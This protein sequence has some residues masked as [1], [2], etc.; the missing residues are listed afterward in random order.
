MGTRY[1]NVSKNWE[2]ITFYHL[3]I[4]DFTAV[5]YCSI[6]HRRVFVMRVLRLVMLY[7]EVF[8]LFLFGLMFNVPVNN[9]LVMLRRSHLFLGITS[10]FGE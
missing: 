3:K 1:S 6:L 8:V 10:T 2:N 5:K 7:S 9:C 4:I